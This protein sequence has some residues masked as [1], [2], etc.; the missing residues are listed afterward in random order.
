MKKNNIKKWA[1]LA[2]F[3]FVTI[4][5]ATCFMACSETDDSIDEF[6]NWQAKNDTYWNNLYTTTKQKIDAG[7]TSWKMILTYSKQN[8]TSPN[9][10]TITY[11][12]ED[13]IIVHVEEA[14]T[15][16]T[17]PIYTDSVRVHYQ[18]RLIPST[19]YTSG[20]IFDSSWSG[21]TFNAKTSRAAHLA[22]TENQ[23]KNTLCNEG[24]TTALQSMHVGDH[25]TVYIPYQLGYGASIQ[26]NTPAYSNLIF[27]LRL[28]EFAHAETA[29]GNN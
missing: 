27:D 7:D 22:V 9:T 26:H 28:V 21:T 1:S 29:L 17:S 19:T 25:W 3:L 8:Q 11:K 6:P 18:G 4:F 13:Y 23:P 15:G 16:T 12:P 2:V 24:L 14:G 5:S 10:N 20:L